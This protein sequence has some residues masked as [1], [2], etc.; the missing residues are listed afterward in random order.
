MGEGEDV[1]ARDGR[2][3]SCLLPCFAGLV[4]T[5]PPIQQGAVVA[6][7]VKGSLFEACLLLRSR[8]FCLFFSVFFLLSQ[9]LPG[10]RLIDVL[11]LALGMT[12]MND[13]ST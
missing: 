3:E 2:K 9:V 11:C 13:D 12:V 5:L 10:A 7:L 4:C 8:S 1:W 6:S